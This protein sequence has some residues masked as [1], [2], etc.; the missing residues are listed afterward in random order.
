MRLKDCN[1]IFSKRG[2]K[3]D[4]LKKWILSVQSF[5]CPLCV[6]M[7]FLF[8]CVCV[9][10]CVRCHVIYPHPGSTPASHPVFLDPSM[11][12]AKDNVVTKDE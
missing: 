2:G 10:A 6:C 9:R 8:V 7:G 4:H 3:K 12:P 5:I 1:L 11:D